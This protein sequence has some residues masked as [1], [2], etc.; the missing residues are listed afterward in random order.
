MHYIHIEHCAAN[1]DWHLQ[2][3][4]M[5][6]AQYGC[7]CVCKVCLQA[8]LLPVVN[9]FNWETEEFCAPCALLLPHTDTHTYT[10]MAPTQ[11]HS[12]DIKHMSSSPQVSPQSRSQF[13]AE[14]AHF[15]P[16]GFLY[17][18]LTE[19]SYRGCRIDRGSLNPRERWEGTRWFIEKTR[20]REAAPL[21]G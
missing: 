1:I 8:F 10:H 21:H 3:G 12:F 17:R 13:L 20:C 7:E 9:V 6:S 15:H 14:S 19:S 5:I 2:Y 4:A 11:Q 18:V 16:Q